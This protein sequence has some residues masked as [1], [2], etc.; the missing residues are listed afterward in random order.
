MKSVIATVDKGQVHSTDYGTSDHLV[1]GV[2]C[3][4]AQLGMYAWHMRMC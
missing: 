4:S 3:P 1:L 2:P